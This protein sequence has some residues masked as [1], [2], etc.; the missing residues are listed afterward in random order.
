MI[1][2]QS[3]KEKN[4]Q[5]KLMPDYAASIELEPFLKAQVHWK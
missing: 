1:L 3:E 4:V 5:D 2:H